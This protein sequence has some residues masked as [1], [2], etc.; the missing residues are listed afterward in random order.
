MATI[1]KF[2]VTDPKPT[3]VVIE[4]F[5]GDNNLSDYILEDLQEMAAGNKGSFVVLGLAD[6][7]GDGGQVVE[8]SP[9]KGL[10]VLETPGEIN[11]GDPETL[12]AFIARALVTY[13]DVPHIALGFWDHGSGV[14]QE[15]DPNEVDLSRA[16]G[17]VSRR[18][19][20]RS[21]PARHLFV[22]QGAIA[23]DEHLR[24]MLHDKTQGDLLTNYEAFGV[25]QSARDR[26]G[27]K[28]KLDL[29]FSDTCL[30]GMV[31]VLDQFK[32]FATVVVGSEELEPGDGW[33]YERLFRMMS[34][35]PP[36]DAAAW[37]TT[38]VDAF[39]AGYRHRPNQQP[40]TLAAFASEN[41]ITAAFGE[42]VTA[43][44]PGGRDTFRL[45]NDVRSRSQGFAQMDTYDI[46]DFATRL[47]A[48]AKGATKSAAT[49][50]AK[51]VDDCCIR[52]A[53]LGDDV[54][55]AHGLAFWFPSNK[56]AFNDTAGTYRRLAFDKSVH[57]ADYLATQLL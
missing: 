32:D 49:K 33:D 48:E 31:E 34:K 28:R 26:A 36:A 8:L 13:K 39:E 5:G 40:C 27:F 1:A 4:L 50:L 55:D 25:L 16:L 2:D 14:F 9:A 7:L 37:A 3:H 30:N 11:T 41:H 46:R 57:W 22:A 54:A 38:A 20:S 23:A 15:N 52:S 29:I 19:V 21:L 17:N 51:A 42:L 35:D 24:A 12:A 43:V 56:R 10:R 6:F 53:A 45:L 47:A 18:S 44:T